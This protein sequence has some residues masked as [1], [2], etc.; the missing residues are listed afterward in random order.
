MHLGNEGREGGDTLSAFGNAELFRL[1]D[2]VGEITAAVGERDD[3]G[4]GT[5]RLQQKG[6][7]IRGIERMAYATYHPA[8]RRL[9]ETRGVALHC[10]TEGE[11]RGHEEPTV[12]ASL[13]DR[14][15]GA[16]G[17]GV[18]VPGP[19]HADWRAGFAREIGS[20]GTRHKEHAVL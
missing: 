17:K 14:L 18:G 11:I 4:A 20:P 12:A 13:N 8:P 16:G 3:L 15:G 10:L 5:L 9:N 6:G 19:M 7:K 2:R 1:L